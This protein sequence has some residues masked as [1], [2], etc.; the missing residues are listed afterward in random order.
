MTERV[1]TVQ[2]ISYRDQERA[3]DDGF[4]LSKLDCHHGRYSVLAVREESQEATDAA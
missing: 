4:T 3:L 2:F 1:W